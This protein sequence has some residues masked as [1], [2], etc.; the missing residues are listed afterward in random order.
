MN[1]GCR[2]VRPL[3]EFVEKPVRREKHPA[4][5]EHASESIEDR[6]REIDRLKWEMKDL[7]KELDDSREECDKLRQRY[8]RIAGVLHE[9]EFELYQIRSKIMFRVFKKIQGLFAPRG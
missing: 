2:A 9:R 6:E 3:A 1:D 7:R 4:F 5:M 8:D